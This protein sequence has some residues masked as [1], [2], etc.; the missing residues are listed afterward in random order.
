MARGEFDH[1][2][3]TGKPLPDLDRQYDPDW[4]ARRYLEQM[5]AQDAADDVRRLIQRE[6]PHLRTMPDRAAAAAR[7]AELNALVAQVN[8]THPLGD[9]IPSIVI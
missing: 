9:L 6:L 8:A 7:A 3:G 4:W 2:P 5:K 1:L